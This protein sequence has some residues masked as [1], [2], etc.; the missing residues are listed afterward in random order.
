MK[1]VAV[2][3]ASA[4]VLGRAA[5]AQTYNSFINCMASADV[6]TTELVIYGSTLSGG[7]DCAVSSSAP[8][9][10]HPPDPLPDPMLYEWLHLCVL[11]RFL[12]PQRYHSRLACVLVFRYS[13]LSRMVHIND[14]DGGC[15][16]VFDRYRLPGLRLEH[17]E[18]I[19]WLFGGWRR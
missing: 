15:Y 3:V 9:G 4:F 6:P 13:A 2:L 17:R 5:S 7:D 8:P 19:C 1:T 18:P 10:R 16:G 14:I 12:D 11:Y